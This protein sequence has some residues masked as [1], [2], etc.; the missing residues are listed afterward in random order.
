ME[1]NAGRDKKFNVLMTDFRR[2]MGYFAV[3]ENGND[4]R[5]AAPM[6]AAMAASSHLPR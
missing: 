2:E 5:G 3:D 1:W 4:T 6:D